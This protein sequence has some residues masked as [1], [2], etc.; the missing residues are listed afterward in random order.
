M[1]LEPTTMGSADQHA[2][3]KVMHLQAMI[4]CYPGSGTR[5]VKHVDN[6]DRDGRCVTAIY[7]FNKLW[8]PHVRLI[9]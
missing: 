8:E 3:H 7:Y 2:N 5:Y 4:A 9:D 6:A 1:G